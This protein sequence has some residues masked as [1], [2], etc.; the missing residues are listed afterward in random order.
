MLAVCEN[1]TQ[2]DEREKKKQPKSASKS[3]RNETVTTRW[4]PCVFLELRWPDALPVLGLSS[5]AGD[6]HGTR[7][8]GKLFHPLVFLS[9]SGFWVSF[10]II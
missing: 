5:P 3:V 7:W 6:E 1:N 9:T 10:S 4:V 2:T 8:G